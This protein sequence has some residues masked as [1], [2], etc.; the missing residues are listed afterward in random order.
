M[1]K[2]QQMPKLKNKKVLII[3]DEPELIESVRMRLEANGYNVIAA[4]DGDEG[5]AKAKIEC[6]DLILLDLIMP[7]VDGLKALSILKKDDRTKLIPVVILTAKSED[8][9]ILDAGRLGAVDYLVKPVN[10]Q[11]LIEVVGRNII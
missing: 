10:M 9:Y 4:A 7:R 1:I 5:V 8:E 6:P 3:D 11:T 2:F